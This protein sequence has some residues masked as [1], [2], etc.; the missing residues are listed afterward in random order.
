M[1]AEDKD[2]LAKEDKELAKKIGTLLLSLRE[3]AG[4]TQEQL[5]EKSGLQSNS[6]YRYEVGE[7]KMNLVTAV[8]VAKVLKV[9]ITRLVPEEYLVKESNNLDP[10]NVLEVFYQLDVEDQKMLMKQML[11]LIAMKKTA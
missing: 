7:R 9:S 3:E 8:R 6:I 2:L 4:M 1:F 10:S 11:A 5:A